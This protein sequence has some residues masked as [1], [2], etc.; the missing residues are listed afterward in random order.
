MD[1]NLQEERV[2]FENAPENISPEGVK[3]RTKHAI[4]SQNAFRHIVRR[5]E[6]K[7]MKVNTQKTGL[8]CI[9]SSLNH[10]TAAFIEDKDGVRRESSDRL[11]VLGWHFSDRP[12]VSAYIDV[13]RRRF[14]E[15]YWVLRHLKRNGFTTEDLL[16]VYKTIV[17]PVADYMQ[18]VYHSCLTDAQYKAIERL[19]SHALGCIYGA[20]ISARRLRDLSGLST[21]RARRI[22][23]VDKFAWKCADSDR[24]CDWFPRKEAGRRTGN[25]AKEEYVEEYARCDRLYNSP[26]FYMRRRLNGK[27]GR[28]NGAR[29]R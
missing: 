4:P 6:A 10:K 8:I 3:I 20:G 16:K 14:R 15:R 25:S 2:N 27:P 1:D 19:Q 29:K 22:E 21:L 5:A 12:N 13:L 26:L 18:E 17:R 28:S 24:F 23:Q 7:G 9:S 11:K